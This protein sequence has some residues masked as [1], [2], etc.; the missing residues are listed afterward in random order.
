MACRRRRRSTAS[1]G[2]LYCSIRFIAERGTGPPEDW[3]KKLQ[4]ISPNE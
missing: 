4:S 2:S 1:Q 3:I